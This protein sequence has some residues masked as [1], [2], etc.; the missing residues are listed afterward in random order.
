MTA[1]VANAASPLIGGALEIVTAR[2]DVGLEAV[3]KAAAL[4]TRAEIERACH[5]AVESD[6]RRFIVAR[7]RLRQHLGVRLGIAPDE[8]ELEYGPH[9]KPAL[10]ARHG[11]S[12]LRFSVSHSDNLAAFAF[13]TGLDIGVDVEKIRTVREADSLVEQFFSPRERALYR[14]LEPQYR[15]RAFFNCWTRKEALVKALGEGLRLPLDSFDV[16]LAPGEPAELLRIDER[17]G[18]ECGWVIREFSPSPDVV[19][20][21]AIQSRERLP[22]AMRASAV[23]DSLALH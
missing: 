7:A 3:C 12:G 5:F 18:A 21:V 13:T 16:T 6:R 23:A 15:Q 2:L 10:A 17:A 1:V 11:D 22:A 4:L 20:A 9:G 8:V 14:A 19:G